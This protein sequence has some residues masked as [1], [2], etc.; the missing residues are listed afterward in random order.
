MTGRS[1]RKPYRVALLGLYHESN[2]FIDRKTTLT[3]FRKGHLL[4]GDGIIAEYRQAYHEIGGMLEVMEREGVEVVPLI[5]AEATPGGIVARSAYRRLLGEMTALL[6]EALPIDGCL[7]VPHGAGVAE[8]QPD[9]DGHW[10]GQVRA[11]VGP[12]V[13]IVGTLDPHANVSQ[14]MVASTDALVAYRTNPHIDQRETGKKAAELMASCLKGEVKLAQYLLKPPV[15]ISIEQQHTAAYPCKPLYDEAAM[16]AQQG[17]VLA[18]SVALGFPY[19]DVSEMG[20]SFL[21]V[22]NDAPQTGAEV[23]KR[24]AEMLVARRHEFV[25]KLAAIGEQVDA[26]QRADKPVLWLDMGD[27]V[28]GGALG[29]SVVLLKALEEDGRLRCFSCIFDPSAVAALWKHGCGDAVVITLG[30]DYTPGSGDHPLTL[31]VRLLRKVDG[32]FQESTPRHG[33]QVQYDMGNTVVAETIN[34]NVVMIHSLRVPPFSLSQ[35]TT[36]GVDPATFDVVIA[37]GVN[38][39]I[40]A[41]GPVCKTI[42]QADT[43]GPTQADMTR[44]PFR[45]RRKPLFPFEELPTEIAYD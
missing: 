44:F 32:K 9:M 16:L 13:P 4:R 14:A 36:F 7:V 18:V 23:A 30:N 34:G 24:L 42:M 26:L 27:N 3:D 15:T 12:G 25:G 45:F 1:Y 40:A 33:G 22:T 10:L 29:D 19:A 20:T 2:T 17:G 35:L 28:G 5:F 43:P 11:L 37:K 31:T 39:P 6:A 21:V 41:Y 8:G 38:A